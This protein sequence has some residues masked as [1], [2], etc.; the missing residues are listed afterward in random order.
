[1]LDDTGWEALVL[2]FGPGSTPRVINSLCDRSLIAAFER[3]KKTVDVDDVYEAAQGMGL[4][5]EIFFYKI[6]LKKGEKEKQVLSNGANDFIKETEIHSDKLNP[7]FNKDSQGTNAQHKDKQPET[8]KSNQA[9]PDIAWSISFEDKKSRK[10]PVLI[11][12]LSIAALILSFFFYCQ[13][14]GSTDAMTCLLEL[15]GF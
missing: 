10:V 15:I 14:S 8:I 1:M 2:A 4:Q 6:A 12:S 3:E 11:I 13:R 5:K 7:S 9:D